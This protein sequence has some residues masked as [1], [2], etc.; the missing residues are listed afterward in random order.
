MTKIILHVGSEK[1]GSTSIQHTLSAS[2]KRLAKRGILY[3]EF[4]K[5]PC[6]IFFT[7][8]AMEDYS[9]HPV[10][11][12]TGLQNQSDYY[13]F[14][15]TVRTIMQQQCKIV[16]PDYLIISDEHIN[17]HLK[18]TEQ[19]A[20]LKAFCN[21]FGEIDS[22][23]IYLRR[24]DSFRLSLFS[25][26]IRSGHITEFD[27]DSPLPIFETIPYRF[28]YLQIL[29]NLAAVFGRDKLRPRLYEPSNFPD[30]NVV[31]D[32]MEISNLPMD[33]VKYKK[34]Q[35]NQ[36]LDARIVHHLAKI[37][38]HLK[39]QET[40]EA[41]RLRKAIIQQCENFY[42]GPGIV[43]PPTEHQ[44]FMAQFEHMNNC[45]QEKYFSDLG[46]RTSLFPEISVEEL[47]SKPQYPGCTID[48]QAFFVHYAECVARIS[49]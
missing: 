12:C 8:C 19:L 2:A 45:I 6:H 40:I 13:R 38:I 41:E 43:L 22:V 5:T 16:S 21:E 34:M 32:F 37:S 3:P 1:T 14:A 47:N 49:H 15:E 18:T 33:A 10:R 17:I 31:K 29:D 42:K 11:K 39:K 25:E 7:A 30:E 36:S 48:W 44:Q 28:D 46:G 26:V 24:Q 35:R 23:I 20:A 4:P 9:D 27:L